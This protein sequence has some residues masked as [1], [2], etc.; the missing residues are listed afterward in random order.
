MQVE[1]F[2]MNNKRSHQNPHQNEVS[3][4]ACVCWS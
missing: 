3:L 4:V 2:H 1:S